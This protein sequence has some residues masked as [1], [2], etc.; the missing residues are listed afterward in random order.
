MYDT[1]G[2]GDRSMND[3]ELAKYKNLPEGRYLLD[4]Y[5]R[6]R[7]L[8][9]AKFMMNDMIGAIAQLM[10]DDDYC[11]GEMFQIAASS[12]GISSLY[13]ALLYLT[14][15]ELSADLQLAI[16]KMASEKGL[17]I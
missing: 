17:Q 13:A 11:L 8:A 15:D 10:D 12:H 16:F 7:T 9:T 2:E 4:Q 6:D 3:G 14:G 5:G 1:T